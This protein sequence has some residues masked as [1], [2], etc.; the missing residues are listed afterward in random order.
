MKDRFVVYDRG[1]HCAGLIDV[2]QFV[3]YDVGEG[4]HL[5]LNFDH[6]LTAL[7]MATAMNDVLEKAGR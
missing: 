5:P 3:I 2:P 1:P 7:R 6:K 4:V